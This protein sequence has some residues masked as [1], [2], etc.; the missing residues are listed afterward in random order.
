MPY[1]G[2][3]QKGMVVLDEPFSLPEGT[4]V[5]VEPLPSTVDD[6]LRLALQVYAGLSTEA[7]AEVERIAFDRRDLFGGD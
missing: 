5:S 6:P 1:R 3:M 2:H 7:I 4:V